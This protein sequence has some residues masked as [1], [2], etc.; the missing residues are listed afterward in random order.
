MTLKITINMDNA[1]F[2]DN[3]EETKHIL[4]GNGNMMGKWSVTL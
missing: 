2:E 4:N 3:L 1:A